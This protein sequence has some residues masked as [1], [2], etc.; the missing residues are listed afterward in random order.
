MDINITWFLLLG[1][2]FT[3]YA[4]LDGFDL[5]VGTL[6]L[7]T[8]RD[9]E[10]RVFLNAIGPVWDGNEVWL[11]VGVGALFGAFPN[12]Y[13]TLFSGFYLLYMLLL[14]GLIFRGVAIEFR[15]KEKPRIWRGFWDVIFALGSALPPV[16]F[17]IMVGNMVAGVPIG[18]DGEF[19]DNSLG[20]LLRPY[21]ILVGF[22]VLSL[23]TLHGA[24]YLNLKTE[25]ALQ[26]RVKTWARRCFYVFLLMYG[27]TT[28]ATVYYYPHMIHNFG[29]H[30]WA[31]VLVVL[32]VLAVANVP[33]T[34]HLGYEVRALV[35]LAC[36]IAGTFTLF[37]IGVFPN[38]LISSIDP[39]YSIT[40]YNSASSHSTLWLMLWMVVIG[41]P[42]IACYTI[43][44]YWVFRGKVSMD[45]PD[46]HGNKHHKDGDDVD[47]SGRKRDGNGKDGRNDDNGY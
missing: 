21:P 35:N 8:R 43:G 2:M 19:M 44:I 28:A 22:F 24:M 40:I 20:A 34:L 17:G 15:N 36:V 23:F 9:R 11:V 1:I 47:G 7:F 39:A 42:F 27:I 30:W 29:E 32:Q 3:F 16:L 5:G 33:R 10:R 46:I 13:A 14:V 45:D 4:V 26:A 38:L 31:W 25:R 6:H 37:G 18:A 41:T 12:A